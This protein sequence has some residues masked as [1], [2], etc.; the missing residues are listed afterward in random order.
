VR[1][2]VLTHTTTTRGSPTQ[3]YVTGRA[4][5]TTFRDRQFLRTPHYLLRFAGLAQKRNL[6]DDPS[7]KRRDRGGRQLLFQNRT[8]NVPLFEK[9]DGAN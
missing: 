6:D 1:D 5:E 2:S 3:V 8:N 9:A 7:P 4:F